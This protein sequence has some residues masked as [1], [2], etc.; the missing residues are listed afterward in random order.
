MSEGLGVEAPD[1]KED[2]FRRCG[3]SW[4]E[5]QQLLQKVKERK[6]ETA[7]GLKAAQSSSSSTAAASSLVSP[8][9]FG[10]PSHVGAAT[11]GDRAAADSSSDPSQQMLQ[12]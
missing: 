5:L 11:P 10:K 9:A 6:S 12:M 8:S 7:R 4:M 2:G 1:K 3:K